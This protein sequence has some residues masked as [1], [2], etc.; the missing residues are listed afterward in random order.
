[1]GGVILFRPVYDPGTRSTPVFP[2]ALVYLAAPLVERGIE[3]SIVDEPCEPDCDARIEELLRSQKPVAVG[4]TSMTGEQIRFGLRLARKVRECS[5][6]AIVWGGIHPSLL[7][8]QTVRHELVD[9]AV[10]GE[11]E[12][13]FV[14]LVERLHAGRDPAGIP[15][16][17]FE[18]DGAICGTRADAY[19]D[20][21]T[22]P[23]LPYHLLDAERYI[24][25]RPDIG[26]ERYF[27]VCTS[28]GCPHH[29]GFCYIECVHGSRWRSLPADAAVER[30]VDAVQRFNLDC[31]SFRE[32][33]FFVSR[34]RVEAIA[35]RLI[36]EKIG[37]KWAASCRINYFDRYSD[38]FIDLLR[39]SGCVLLTFGVESGC[40]R[41]LK[42]IRKDITVDQVRRVAKRLQTAGIRST[43]H[44]MGGFPGETT[45]EFIE[46]CRLIDELRRLGSEVV[47]REMSIFAP[48]PGVGL[49]PECVKGGY[50]EP[51]DLEAWIRMD[52]ANP[53]RP[54][55]TERQSRVISDAQFLIARLN[56][57]N[58]LARAWV[59]ARWRQLLA[60]KDGITL[61]ERPLLGLVRRL[62]RSRD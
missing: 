17:F 54:W 11:G 7:P 6:A 13:A 62:L 61:S 4:I 42:A 24:C 48:Y 2:W 29:C 28:R 16:V 59:N 40:D 30:I 53:R 56:H 33:N 14:E 52:W 57:P 3:V 47:V 45:P 32:D 50:E 39:R 25:T 20:L 26:A 51:Q 55:L 38:E 1:M 5:A 8:E 34:S 58:P 60:S 12:H 18:K 44:F 10:A 35:R 23:E 37:I 43:Y 27:E 49:I 46:T 22:L 15:G 9:Y 41:V 21:S 36:E 19:L 31:V